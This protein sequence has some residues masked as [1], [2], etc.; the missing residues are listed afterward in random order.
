MNTFARHIWR[1]PPIALI[2][3]YAI[4]V[5]IEVASIVQAIRQDSW[6]PMYTTGWLPAV[7]VAS[8]SPVGARACR[9]RLARR[10]QHEE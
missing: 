7:V 3:F 9:L 10:A 4:A 6:G 2:T 8:S 5:F 1:L